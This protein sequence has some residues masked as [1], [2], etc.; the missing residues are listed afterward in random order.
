[1]IFWCFP[2][3][4]KETIGMKLVNWILMFEVNISA[5]GQLTEVTGLKRHFVSVKNE[6]MESIY[7]LKRC[8]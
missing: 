8:L 2:R 6:G 4:L 1:M 5:K 7:P 3:A